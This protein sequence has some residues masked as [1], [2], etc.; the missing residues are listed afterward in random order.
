MFTTN[1]MKKIAID[2]EILQY[3]QML[4]EPSHGKVL[5]YIKS[6]FKKPPH[7][8]S[9]NKMLEFAGAFSEKDLNEFKNAIELGC[10]K[11]DLNEW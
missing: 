10:E 9:K 7:D 8:K 3:L 2:N 4:E 5:S 6:L 11:P 1:Q